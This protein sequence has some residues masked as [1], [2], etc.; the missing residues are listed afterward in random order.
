MP[1]VSQRASPR[2]SN[3]E[4]AENER[5][6]PI[7]QAFDRVDRDGVEAALRVDRHAANHTEP[8]EFDDV[9]DVEHVHARCCTG[10]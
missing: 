5:I 3:G 7:E 1:R 10:S 4:H 8:L 2:S 9:P 6:D